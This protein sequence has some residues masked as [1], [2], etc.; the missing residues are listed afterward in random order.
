[1]SLPK[2]ILG[3]PPPTPIN[4]DVPAEG[5]DSSLP[6]AVETDDPEEE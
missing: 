2:P 6:T 5:E 1:M 3:D 4:C